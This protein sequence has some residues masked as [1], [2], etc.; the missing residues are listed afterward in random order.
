MTGKVTADQK[1]FSIALN[2]LK[3]SLAPLNQHLQLR[4]FLVG[5][6]LT[7]ADVYVVVTLHGAWNT[8]LDKKT[9]DNTIPNV[10]RYCTL[11]S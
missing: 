5:H 11:L 6:R 10:A 1:S 3:A 7:L 2:E 8:V 4:N 9:R